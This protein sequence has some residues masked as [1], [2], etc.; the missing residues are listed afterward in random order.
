MTKGWL[1]AEKEPK[2]IPKEDNAALAVLRELYPSPILYCCVKNSTTSFIE[3]QIVS[4]SLSL[5]YENHFL[6]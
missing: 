4:I 3:T 6:I 5:Q 1:P 2:V